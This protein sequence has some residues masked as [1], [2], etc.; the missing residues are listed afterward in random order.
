MALW[1]LQGKTNTWNSKNL[2]SSARMN[3]TSMDGVPFLL[4]TLNWSALYLSAY[5]TDVESSWN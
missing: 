4:E 3:P 2:F 1:Y 5:V